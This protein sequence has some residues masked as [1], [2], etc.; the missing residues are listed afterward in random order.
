MVGRISQAWFYW[1]FNLSSSL[2][3]T[4]KNSVHTSTYTKN[5][6]T[7]IQLMM[8]GE[9]CSQPHLLGKSMSILRTVPIIQE[10]TKSLMMKF[11]F[12]YS[13]DHALFGAEILISS[14][15]QSA[16]VCLVKRERKRTKHT[17]NNNT[18]SRMCCTNPV[19]LLCIYK[20]ENS[21]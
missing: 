2:R 14:P 8:R 19:C 11:T 1:S 7:H 21:G 13:S 20:S 15:I 12:Y 18:M 5:I 16:R 4:A 3:E 9:C 10:H 6:R 17:Y